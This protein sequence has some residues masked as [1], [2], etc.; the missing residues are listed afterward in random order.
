MIGKISRASVFSVAAVVLAGGIVTALT[1]A[2]EPKNYSTLRATT[3]NIS[4]PK[5]KDPKWLVKQR[6]AQAKAATPSTSKVKISQT[7]TYDVTT[8]G[9]ITADYSTFKQLA[10][11]TLNDAR[12]WSRLGVRFSEVKSGGSFT[13]V[14][15]SASEVAKFSSGCDSTY[16]CRVGR[17][18]VINQDR[19]L[20]ATPAWNNGGGSLRDYRNMVVN[21][22]TGHWL[23][24]EH[25][26]CSGSGQSA[27]VMQQQSIS[28]QGC[29][30]NPWPLEKELNSTALG[31]Q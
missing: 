14:L 29:K 18:V 15:A 2:T 20:G 17:Y 3:E 4:M 30:F 11:E 10:N 28:L 7:V 24:H 23:G 9:T 5:L 21:H 16:S 13:L 31:I 12:G 27:P 6:A 25:A 1:P 8:R 22:E 19:W 26:Y